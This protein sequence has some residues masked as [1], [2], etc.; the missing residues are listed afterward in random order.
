[1]KLIPL[2]A[3]V[4]SLLVLVTSIFVSVA[5]SN[6][7]NQVSSNASVIGNQFPQGLSP[8][9]IE[10]T[11]DG[12]YGYLSFDLAEVIF[13][14]YLENLTVLAVADLS[15]YF[16]TE[17]QIMVL[18]A[19]E[20]KLFA[21]IPTSQKLIIVDTQTM[22]I[23]HTIDNINIV[24][25]TK[26]QYGR[27]LIAPTGGGT[28]YFVNTDTYQVTQ[29]T[30]L[31]GY[32][33]SIKESGF[34]KNLWYVVSH[35][36]PWTSARAGIY[37]YVKGIWT[38]SVD[39]SLHSSNEALFDSEILPNEQKLYINSM[40]GWYPE[41]HSYGWLYSID[42][43][44]GSGVNVIPIDGD[45]GAIRASKDSKYLYVGAGWPVPDDRNLLVFDTQTDSEVNQIYLGRTIYGWPYTQVNEL[46]IDPAHSNILYATV[47]DA[48]SLI[49]VNLDS[50]TLMDKIVFNTE[51]YH[52]HFFARQPNQDNGYILIHQ[53]A[54]AFKLNLNSATIEK[55]DTLPN[56]RTD[57]FSYDVAMNNNGRLII[58]QGESI[59]E[60]NSK[61]M[62][63]IASHPLPNGISGLW[64]LI[65]SNDQTKLYSIWQNQ[66]QGN[67]PNTFLAIDTSNF[68]VQARL[69]LEG[70]AFF[71]RPFELPDGS[72]L[73]AVGG[74][75]NGAII[76]HVIDA[77]DYTIHKTITFN[78]T[79]LLG[80]SAGP[81]Y[82]IS[83][84]P[85]SH[86]LFVGAT[87]VVL[88]IDT[89]TDE[90]KKVINL[91]DAARAIGLSPN[92]L[93]YIN[94]D[95][96]L[97][98]PRE[99]CLYIAHYDRSFVSIYNLTSNEFL[100]LAISLQGFAP[101]ML[102]SN[103]DFSKIYCIMT[104][105]DAVAVIDVNAKILEKVIDL[106]SFSATATK[107]L[108]IQGN[109]KTFT[110]E[111]TSNASLS[112]F[113][114]SHSSKQISFTS[115]GSSFTFSFP[116]FWNVTFPNELLWG[117]LAV[118]VNG[119]PLADAIK[120][121]NS[122]HT[123][124]YFSYKL[125]GAKNIQIT[126]TEVEPLPTP[127]PSLSPTSSQSPAVTPAQTQHP[128]IKSST[129]PTAAPTEPSNPTSTPTIP[130]LATTTLA[131]ILSVATV[132][133]ITLRRKPR[134]LSSN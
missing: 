13:K 18:D 99:N 86:T 12:K 133:L 106:H 101:G 66:T 80:I 41:T 95:G 7:P 16:P 79:S 70:G 131:I 115:M 53:S 121:D 83:Y 48:N 113:D 11:K 19:T 98:N 55:I 46:Q 61:D 75:Q 126:G 129:S 92:Q 117:N 51:S 25:L 122:T 4:L 6:Q 26:S 90:I 130:E 15:N 103:D 89:Q 65:L 27:V 49:K 52:P 59:L 118:Q 63:L 111:V 88:A 132:S 35:P 69:K 39:I 77:R 14:V 107:A 96:L 123:S 78:E 112:T 105:S 94:A 57:S 60:V 91:G 128:T 72:K 28:V 114:F 108:T 64:S 76:I 5:G 74:L 102:F 110:V 93:T 68:Q 124:L 9:S 31:D 42:L 71:N 50:L 134:T 23:I 58:N 1:M 119:V 29:L 17:C 56:I 104:R 24:E 109:T 43:T 40:G 2:I 81:F 44:G 3:A 116:F 120:I 67:Y 73:Y 30:G 10:I 32:F 22:N 38:F 8:M 47:T 100:P 33:I 125:Q 20:T 85:N 37:D 34:D 97:F 84:D 36:P 82:P 21:F 54:N 45:A 62:Q 87:Y 127:T